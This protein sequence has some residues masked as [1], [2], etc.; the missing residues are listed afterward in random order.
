MQV[1]DD[2]GHDQCGAGRHDQRKEKCAVAVSNFIC[3]EHSPPSMTIQDNFDHP[4][5]V[6]DK[7][8]MP[9]IGD[10]GDCGST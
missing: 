3:H 6:I 4:A 5:G 2:A 1:D 7:G 10:R 8:K 9:G